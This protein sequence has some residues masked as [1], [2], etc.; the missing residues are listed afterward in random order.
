MELKIVI[1]FCTF[2]FCI[3]GQDINGR[4]VNGEDADIAD[5][6][7]AMALLDRGRF[8]CGASAISRFWALSAGNYSEF[9]IKVG[10]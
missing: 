5:F 7:H 6:P 2:I 4:I 8:F 9:E 1:V 10:D 3:T